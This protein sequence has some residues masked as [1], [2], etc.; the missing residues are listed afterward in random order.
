M[1][2]VGDEFQEISHS[3]GQVT[4]TIITREDGRHSYQVGFRSC[5]PVPFALFAIYALPPGIPVGD[6]KMGG[7]GDPWNPP[8]LPGCL[9]VFIASDSHGL[10]GQQCPRCAGYWRSR[11][12]PHVCPYCGIVDERHNF[13]TDAQRRYVAQYCQKLEE[14]LS[15]DRDGEHIIDMDA[16]A[17]AVGKD[18]EKPPFYYAEEK[19]QNDFICSAC[20]D[21]NDIIGRF[22]Y[23]SQCGTRNDLEQLE[24]N[25][26]PNIRKNLNSN[27]PSGA[28][29]RDVASTFDS[30][31]SQYVKQLLD[32]VPMIPTRKKRLQSMRFHNLQAVRDEQNQTF[33]IDLFSGLPVAD[34]KHATLMFSRRHVYEHNG[35]EVDERYMQE[36]GDQTVRLK[37]AL[38]EDPESLHR[39][40]GIV[41]RMA[42]NLH[43][44]FHQIFPPEPAPIKAF[45]EKKARMA[46]HQKQ[47]R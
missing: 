18:I 46:K 2:G 21:R 11:G 9:P 16:V 3:G 19:Q 27:G 34:V 17:N 41:A 40:V 44:G 6:V 47:G 36:S 14:A 26:I 30:F 38:R 10:F 42:R 33:G 7:I 39:F 45:Q 35:G 12:F 4:F 22:G 8:P 25:I 20:E 23:C 32:A 24:S 15:N 37:Q 31:V 29:L 43:E 1:N 13:L 5:R 28:I